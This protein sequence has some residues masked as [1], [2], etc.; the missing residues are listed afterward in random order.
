[1]DCVVFVLVITETV[2][3]RTLQLSELSKIIQNSGEIVKLETF[4]QHQIIS[5]EELSNLNFELNFFGCTG[6]N[7]VK[8]LY[9]TKTLRNSG[10][11][12]YRRERE[13]EKKKVSQR[14]YK[15]LN[16]RQVVLSSSVISEDR[17][18]PV[19]SELNSTK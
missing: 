18:L 5:R 6:Q 8:S 2:Y 1:M 10:R 11:G 4:V 13:R 17:G 3:L 7:T 12:E 15:G 9:K 16:R 14:R 19:L